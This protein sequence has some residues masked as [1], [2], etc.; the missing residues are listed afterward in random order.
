MVIK[1]ALKEAEAKMKA[2]Q[3]ALEE[4]PMI[5]KEIIDQID[6]AEFVRTHL[7]SIN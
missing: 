5:I 3:Q 1:E 4:I 6:K 7:I 2:S